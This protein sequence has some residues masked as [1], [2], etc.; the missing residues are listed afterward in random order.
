MAEHRPDN[1]RRDFPPELQH[2]NPADGWADGKEWWDAR[3][4]YAREHG[5]F[6]PTASGRGKILPLIQEM[7]KTRGGQR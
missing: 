3:I 5:T 7:T 4:E 6:G 2:Y 1:S